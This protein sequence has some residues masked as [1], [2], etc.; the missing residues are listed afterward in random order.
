[1]TDR[2][3]GGFGAVVTMVALFVVPAVASAQDTSRPVASN[4]ADALDAPAFRPMFP[5]LTFDVAA[6]PDQAPAPVAFEYSDGYRARDRIHHLASYA[7]LPLFAAQVY[8]GQKLFNDP[9]NA[10]P[11]LRHLHGTL[12]IAITGLFAV[13]SLTGVWNL[14][15]ARH[16]P[17]G[18]FRRTMHGV[19]MLVADAG[20]VATAIDRPNGRSER[21]AAIFTPKAN[22]HLALAYASLSVATAGYL[23]MLFR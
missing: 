23:L 14:V 6:A 1:M 15:E 8:V 20:F 7:T 5:H 13:N 2:R 4:A 11:G 17:H 10:T 3:V 19:L 12:A 22:Q 21:G 9:A 16:D 18:S